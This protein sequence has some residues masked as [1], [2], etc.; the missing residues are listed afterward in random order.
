MSLSGYR[1][2]GKRITNEVMRKGLVEVSVEKN[3]VDMISH[4]RR[5][6]IDIIPKMMEQ[7]ASCKGV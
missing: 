5:K 1:G 6:R 4:T 2:E 3:A 7:A